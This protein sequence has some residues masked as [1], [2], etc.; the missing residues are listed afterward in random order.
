MRCG[1]ATAAAACA[2][3]A[4]TVPLEPARNLSGASGGSVVV[5]TT[6]SALSAIAARVLVSDICVEI[7]SENE[8]ISETAIAQTHDFRRQTDQKTIQLQF[9]TS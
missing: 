7:C 9:T 8:R 5:D 4:D 2:T 1:L 3:T 6:A